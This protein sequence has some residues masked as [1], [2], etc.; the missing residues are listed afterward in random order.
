MRAANPQVPPGQP[1]GQ[2]FAGP[3][4]ADVDVGVSVGHEANGVYSQ[5]L[6]GIESARQVIALGDNHHL[7]QA[8]DGLRPIA[9]VIGAPPGIIQ[10]DVLLRHSQR[11]GDLPHLLRL[12]VIHEAVIAAEEEFADPPGPVEFHRCRH[13]VSQDVTGRT[14]GPVASAEDQRHRA[15]RHRR[16]VGGDEPPVAHGQRPEGPAPDRAQDRE[17]DADE[18]G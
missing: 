7:P 12:V 1:E 10:D 13:P 5:A 14:V 17:E 9:G 18:R 3:V 11:P 8:E 2:D 16:R 4:L 6:A 15:L